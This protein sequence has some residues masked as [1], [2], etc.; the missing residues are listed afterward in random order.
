MN[1]L[2]MLKHD[3]LPKFVLLNT[4]IQAANPDSK[5]SDA[6]SIEILCLYKSRYTIL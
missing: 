2:L 6:E 3:D 5:C 1:F 4:Q